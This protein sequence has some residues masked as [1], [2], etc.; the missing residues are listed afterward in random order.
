MGAKFNFVCP[1]CRYTAGWL[2]GGRSVGMMAVVR[3]MTCEDCQEL[4]DVLIGR[5]GQD[6]LTG[7]INHDETLNIC[8]K[9][10]GERL[11][12]WPTECP[13]PR[14]GT[15]MTKDETLGRMLWD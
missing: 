3:T 4:V 1:G 5:H 2:A 6:G 10:Q 8:P 9:C 12:S 7:D 14:C 11:V 13:C 15:N